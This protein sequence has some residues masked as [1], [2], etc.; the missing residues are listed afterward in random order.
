MDQI[1]EE[2]D[3]LLRVIRD[4]YDDMLE[5][6]QTL[7]TDEQRVFDMGE[8]FG[9]AKEALKWC[10]PVISAVQEDGGAGDA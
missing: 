7:D 9:A 6:Y 4:L 1:Y 10:R 5:M 3:Q 8:L 2:H